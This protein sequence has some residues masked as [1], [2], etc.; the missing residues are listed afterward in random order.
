M[1]KS[2]TRKQPPSRQRWAQK[3]RAITF[4][5][6]VEEYEEI[7]AL[8]EIS[9]LSNAELIRQSWSGVAK[10]LR[11]VQRRGYLDGLKTGHDAGHADGFKKGYSH[12]KARY[13]ITWG[14]GV[15]E[16]VIAVLAG[17]RLAELASEAISGEVLACKRCR[18]E[19]A[20]HGY[21][22]PPSDTKQ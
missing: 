19:Q 11:D 5:A 2:T 16:R 8:Q 18:D 22:I 4:H 14:C 21:V 1:T 17:S 13:A 7:H 20:L 10:G 12:A 15:C 6:T 9:G 3:H